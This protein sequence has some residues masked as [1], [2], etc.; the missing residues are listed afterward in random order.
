MKK[1][2]R[3]YV[4]GEDSEV[5]GPRNYFRE[6]IMINS[7]KQ[8]VKSGKI[9]DAGCGT[10]SLSIRLANDGYNL[11]SMDSSALSL[12][13]LIDKVKQH[14]LQKKIVVKKGSILNMPF[15]KNFFDGVVCGEVLEHMKNDKKALSEIQRVL[16]PGGVCIVTT[17]GHPENWDISDYI[18]GHE[19]RYTKADLYQKFKDE[20]FRNISCNFI[21]FPLNNLWHKFIYVPYLLKKMQNSKNMKHQKSKNSI[22]MSSQF[23]QKLFS[24]IF[25]FDFIF[26]FLQ[27][28]NILLVTAKK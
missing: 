7:L 4:W 11:V 3:N 25:Y 12:R 14:G 24:Q 1:K 22:F 13:H 18:S 27:K 2:I 8:H 9:L 10:G 17:P 5:S 6:S 16:K 21:G 23:F 28:G 19:R 26:Y 20:H 15:R